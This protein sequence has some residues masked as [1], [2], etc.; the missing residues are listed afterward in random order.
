MKAYQVVEWGR[1]PEFADV[2]KPV[3]GPG[4]VLVRMKGAGL[5]RSDLDIMDQPAGGEPYA[6]VLP[7]GFTLGHE[8]AGV[9]EALG[10]GVTDLKE[11]DA[12]VVHHMQVC[13]FCDYCLHGHEQSCVTYTRKAV[14]IT[15]GVG[16]DGGLAPFLKVARKEVLPIGDLD[17]VLVAPLTD[18]GVTA[19][20]AIKSV[21]ERLHPG[22]HAAVIGLG[23]LGAYG[24]QFLK[25]LTQ[26]RIFALD[27]APARLDL[28]HE[29]GADH[30]IA[31]DDRA[32]E[33]IMDLSGGR[34]ADV[35]IDFV[36]TN[37]T[38]ATAAKVSR[39]QGRII[40]VGM[41][42]GYLPMGW[43]STASSCEFAISLGSKRADL[44]EVCQLAA[45][46]RLRIDIERYAFDDVE[47]AYANLRA[48]KLGGRA[49]VT[50]D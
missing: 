50:F 20:R 19:Y 23:G 33:Q 48:G 6:H 46:D 18:A 47:T 22:T 30:V 42:G 3:A 27:V 1:P 38:L 8:N 9:I 34:G 26:A 5:C 43:G 24:V 4:E 40:L 13:G 41:E 15:R 17:P 45:D 31:S 14:P 11:G 37:A 21:A 29:L 16:I 28:A 12:V 36:G 39:A 35:I 7:A 2:V 49:V 32:A 25:I 44:R 10:A